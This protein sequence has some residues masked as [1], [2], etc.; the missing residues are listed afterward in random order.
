VREPTKST[1]SIRKAAIGD[2]PELIELFAA[3]ATFERSNFSAIGL[4]KR[5][6]TTLFGDAPRAFVFVAE[7]ELKLAGYASCSREFSTWAGAEFLHMDCLFVGETFRGKGLGRKLVDVIF[8]EAK[9]Q[10]ISEVQWQTPDWNGCAIKFY[11]SLG[12]TCSL[13][14]RFK[15]KLI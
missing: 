11:R 10:N 12:A 13:K 7:L 3:H 4:H 14:A 8:G 9:R 5:L 15:Q 6:S 2:L 1:A